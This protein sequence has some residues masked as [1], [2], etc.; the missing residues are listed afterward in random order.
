MR[1]SAP[2]SRVPD[3]LIV[4]GGLVGCACAFHLAR[5]G[6]QV[7]LAEASSLNAGASGQTAGSLHFQIERR[8]LEDDGNGSGEIDRI[9]SLNRLAIEEWTGLENALSRDLDIT[10]DGG[11]MLAESEADLALLQQKSA[12]EAAA[13][14]A[15]RLLD[16]GEARA[17]L[18]G[19]SPTV[20]GA[21]FQPHEGHANPRILADAYA[22]AARQLGA[23]IRTGT[24]LDALSMTEA[25]QYRA[26]LVGPAGVETLVVPQIFV[27]AGAWTASI[28][29]RLG[30]QLPLFPVPLSLNVTDKGGP[31]LPYLVQH[32]GK[33]LSLK[34]SEAGNF[35][36]GG[37]W[38]SRFAFRADGSIDLDTPPLPVAESVSGNLQAAID[39]M[40]ALRHRSLVRSW[41][42]ITCISADQL[43]IA[44]MLPAAP[45]LFVAAGG[46]MFTMGPVI[47]R[48]LAAQIMGR[49]EEADPI[50][51]FT[52]ARFAHLNAFAVL[53]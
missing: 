15:T 7:L 14:L 6:V 37:G 13:G 26:T 21:A 47:A 8:F 9:V 42:G 1:S 40:P 16:A 30:L 25:R 46:S 28:V 17:M 3:V 27:A 5:A 2:P 35:L 39:V 52:P 43:P 51:P 11:L 45:G 29:G 44:G 33:R 48:L 19:L 32:V 10:M 53:P 49:A 4:G 24:R 38:A 34:Q 20:R 23:T 18:P 50:A 31:E 12:R 41:T 22:D 36:I